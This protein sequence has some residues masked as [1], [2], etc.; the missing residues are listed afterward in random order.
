MTAL[1]PQRDL[2]FSS[3]LNRTL[4]RNYLLLLDRPL[5]VMCGLK[6]S[7]EPVR[8]HIYNYTKEFRKNEIL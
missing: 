3:F 8:L 7:A 6:T 5:Q 1:S 2:A 4:L